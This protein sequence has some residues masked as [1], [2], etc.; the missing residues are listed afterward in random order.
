MRLLLDTHLLAWAM[1]SP[2]R[3]P[4]ELAAM[5]EHPLN[6]PVFSVGHL[7]PLHR[8]PFDR[9]LLITTDLQLTAYPSCKGF[10]KLALHKGKSSPLHSIK[11]RCRFN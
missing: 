1:G 3:L 10:R 4:T 2:E 7:P 11:P 8:D 5:L 9:L 6:T